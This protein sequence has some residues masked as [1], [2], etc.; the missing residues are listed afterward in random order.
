MTREREDQPRSFPRKR[1]SNAGV[2][3][4]W[5]PAFAGTSDRTAAG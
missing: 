3:A 2:R 5:V 4:I 1:E